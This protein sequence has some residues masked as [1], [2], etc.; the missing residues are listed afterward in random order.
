MQ[1]LF[2]VAIGFYL[3]LVIGMCVSMVICSCTDWGKK[4]IS[5]FIKKLMFIK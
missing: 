2:G 3:G 4:K 5:N 1:F